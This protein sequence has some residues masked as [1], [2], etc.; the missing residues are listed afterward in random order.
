MS[1]TYDALKQLDAARY[2]SETNRE[3][4]PGS[5]RV[6][7]VT[8]NKGGVGKTTIAT[9]LA[10]YL[11][12]L[13]NDQPVL[14]LGL[15]EQP[16]PDRMFELE[17]D[18]FAEATTTALRTGRLAQAIRPGRYDIDYVPTSPDVYELKREIADPFH[19]KRLIAETNRRGFV[20]ID[21]KSDFEILTQNAIAASD[22]AIVVVKDEAS[23]IEAQK[24]F[25][26]LDEWNLPRERAR[27]LLSLV[28][29]RIKY[30]NEN[31]RDILAYLVGEMKRR[32][33][34]LFES[35]ISRSPKIESLYT[36]PEGRAPAIALGANGSLVHRQM[37]KL[38]DEV[39]DALGSDAPSADTSAEVGEIAANGAGSPAP[40]EV[41]PEDVPV[42][43]PNGVS[44]TPEVV[45]L[46]RGLTPVAAR[47]L[48]ASPLRITR[49]PFSIG[50]L[51]PGVATDL[52][53]ADSPPWQVSRSHVQL[54]EANGRIGVVDQQSR[55]GT[56]VDG[57]PL[58]GSR[59]Q[60]GPLFFSDSGGTLVLGNS[61][62]PYSYEV[63]I[64]HPRTH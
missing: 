21:T 40:A 63:S 18:P 49:F 36:N 41:V 10:V 44:Q 57:R 9:N 22:L 14:V 13:R 52:T 2:L 37:R 59:G 3:R 16:M 11:R 60:P 27:I 55:L 54:I 56:L 8:N 62:S 24:V 43:P 58:A 53:I 34:P 19:L 31:Q 38:A 39:L 51:D 23:L 42:A 1:R 48:P 47:S 45:V 17:P 46:L 61:R 50:R 30:R 15:D 35:F 20:V 33:Y 6:V 26:L 64:Q 29:L 5:A 28:D 32:G 25:D 12:G 7:T 4:I